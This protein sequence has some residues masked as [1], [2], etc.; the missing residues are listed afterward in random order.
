[1]LTLA[2][3]ELTHAG[4]IIEQYYLFNQVV[5]RSINNA[6][7]SSKKN[8]PSLVVETYND[9]G[10]WQTSTKFSRAAEMEQIMIM[11]W[12]FTS[13]SSSFSRVKWDDGRSEKECSAQCSAIQA[14]AN[15]H[16][17]RDL[18]PWSRDPKSEALTIR[19]P[20]PAVIIFFHAQLSWAW[21]FLCHKYENEIFMLSYVYQERIWHFYFFE[22]C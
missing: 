20:G 11:I 7:Y 2:Q 19:P 3:I 17:Q 15:F 10:F 6:V 5:R 4:E 22:I 16:L 9:A 21:N 13:L 14:W 8:T 1:M 12:C 18:N